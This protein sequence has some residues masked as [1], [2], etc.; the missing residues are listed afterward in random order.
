MS[1]DEFLT[2]PEQTG[3]KEEL[4]SGFFVASPTARWGHNE[5]ALELAAQLRTAIVVPG[6][7]RISGPQTI[8]LDDHA[9]PQPD[10]CVILRD[11]LHIVQD[12]YPR[13][14]PDLV[15][16]VLSPGNRSTDLGLKKRLYA[17][18]GVREY[19]LVDGDARTVTQFVLRNARYGAATVRRRSLR[20]HIVPTAHLDLT[21]LW[22][23]VA[24][25]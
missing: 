21:A 9:A 2:R 16:E 22:R 13:G 24:D 7:G 18:H 19:L 14:A 6:L 4:L 11:R 5:L 20:L 12:G 3:H 15:V 1:L 10:L 8:V 25:R 17:A 23:A